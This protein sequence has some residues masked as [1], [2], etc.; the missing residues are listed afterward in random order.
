MGKYSLIVDNYCLSIPSEPFE[1]WRNGMQ[2]L[3][4]SCKHSVA[5]PMVIDEQYFDFHDEFSDSP[6][7]NFGLSESYVIVGLRKIV[8]QEF[9]PF[10]IDSHKNLLNL[11]NGFNFEKPDRRKENSVK[12]IELYKRLIDRTREVLP[13]M[14]EIERFEPLMRNIPNDLGIR[15]SIETAFERYHSYIECF[16]YPRFR[17]S[18]CTK[19]YSSALGDYY[20]MKGLTEDVRPDEMLFIPADDKF[21]DEECRWNNVRTYKGRILFLEDTFERVDLILAREKKMIDLIKRI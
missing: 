15:S 9:F 21:Y 14:K 12:I 2:F 13:S 3:Y 6:D 20:I 17:D 18:R 8:F 11:F 10:F 19:E 16:S 1:E 7:E 4:D 5:E